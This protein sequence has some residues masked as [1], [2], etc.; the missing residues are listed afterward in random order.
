MVLKGVATNE[1]TIAAPIDAVF[2]TLMDP[3][4]YQNWVVGTKR[5]RGADE[6]WPQVGS[7]FHHT[8]GVGPLATRDKST[9]LEIR[10]PD[11]LVLD[12]AIW[13]AGENLV[14]FQLKDRGEITEVRLEEEA[15]RG[16]AR[17][18]P[19][20][21]TDFGFYWRNVLGLKRF[22]QLVEVRY[23]TGYRRNPS[24]P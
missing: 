8:V 23:R 13:P 2:D 16:P 11:R 19:R 14:V 15:L 17:F 18:V 4:S 1:I 3:A 20:A 10:R 9:V 21:L 24:R 12:A 7:S 22:K 6:N 5:V